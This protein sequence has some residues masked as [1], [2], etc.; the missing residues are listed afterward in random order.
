[1]LI[2]IVWW[3]FKPEALGRSASDNAKLVKN[4]LEGLRGAIPELKDLRVGTD[5]L[6]S[7]TEAADLV[8]VTRHDNQEGLAVYAAHPEH[9]KV[10]AVLKEATATRKALD[11]ME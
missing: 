9:Q 10:V 8:L 6:N 1:M 2:H 5:L 3:T 11:F 4:M 7:S